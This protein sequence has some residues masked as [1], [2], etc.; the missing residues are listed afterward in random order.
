MPFL[1]RYFKQ[2]VGG[3]SVPALRRRF[4]RPWRASASALEVATWR[5]SC[6]AALAMADIHPIIETMEHRW[7]RAWVNG[8][9]RALKGLTA[10]KFRMVIASKPCMLLDSKSWLEAA[11]T[12]FECSSY[13]F[14]DIYARDLGSVAVFG[15]QLTMKATMD[16]HDWSGQYW[17]TDLW[18][19]TRIRRSWRMVERVISR[20]EE[21]PEVSAA[22][23]SLQ[24]WR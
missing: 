7:M 22:I 17:V 14:G 10:G 24:L 4:A 11:G 1:F 13:R 21:K 15:T 2:P 9:K 16:G 18:R 8:D 3:R 6:S 19:K 5:A 23:R 20:P 12:R